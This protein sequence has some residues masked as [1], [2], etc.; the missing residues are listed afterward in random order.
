MQY[1]SNQIKSNQ[2]KSNQIKPNQNQSPN[3][4]HTCEL[5][6]FEILFTSPWLKNCAP[7]MSCENFTKKKNKRFLFLL[8]SVKG[9]LYVQV[10]L[11]YSRFL[12]QCMS[13]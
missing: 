7:Q 10:R 1:K 12:S 13:S 6:K 11:D 9:A 4:P 8:L 5:R 3:I 2:I